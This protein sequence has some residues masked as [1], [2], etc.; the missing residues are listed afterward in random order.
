MGIFRYFGINEKH[1]IYGYQI[2]NDFITFF[3]T[4]GRSY[5]ALFPK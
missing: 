5:F 2:V 4:L 3:L 1:K